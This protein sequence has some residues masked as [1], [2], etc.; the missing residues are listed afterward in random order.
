MTLFTAILLES[1]LALLACA[2]LIRQAIEGL[3]EGRTW[4]P[5]VLLAMALLIAAGYG[6]QQVAA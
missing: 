6:A 2:L 1:L 5:A 3:L 4:P